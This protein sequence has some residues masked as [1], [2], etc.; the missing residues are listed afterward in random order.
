[1]ASSDTVSSLTPAAR[2]GECVV[3]VGAGLAGLFTA[4]K[5]SPH[6]VVLISPTPLG[7]G[8]ASG[9]AQGGI[10]A[11]MSEGDTPEAH[12]LDT[13]R[14]GCGIVD[15][16]MA[17]LLAAE[18]AER[19]DDLLRLGVPFDR[20]LEGKL[21]L[22]REAAHG[23]RRI[24]RV[25]GD[26]AGKAIMSAVT[27]AVRQTPSI[28][29][30]T[31]AGVH[32]LTLS[33]G[34]VTGVRVW[35]AGSLGRGEPEKVRAR[36]VVLAS[37]GIGQLYRVTTNPPG[38]CGEG[39]AIAARAGATIADAEFVQF[40]PT[41]LDIGRDPAPLAT[42]ALRGEGALLINSQGKRY[43]VEAHE[44]AELAPR[45]VV[46]RATFGEIQAGRGAFIDCRKAIG[47]RFAE[48]FPALFEICADAGI[49]PVHQ[50]IP[51]APAAHYHMG[52]VLT[53]SDGRTTVDGLW[54][55]GEVACTG[56][57]GANRLA[58][59]SLLET[60]V[61]G[62][63]IANDISGYLPG[64]TARREHAR[65]PAPDTAT[66]T[67]AAKIKDATAALRQTMTSNAGVVRDAQGL[68]DA[69]TLVSQLS[70]SG[71][72]LAM[73]NWALTARFIA[74]AA[75]RREESRG[76]H[77]RTDFPEERRAWKRHSFLTLDD[78]RKL[79]ETAFRTEHDGGRVVHAAFGS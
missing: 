34:Q 19:I 48:A 57:H 51:I 4:L 24:A 8:T 74:V 9:W 21:Q 45:D 50:P 2:R 35:P 43:M 56:A 70:E 54:A 78:V 27:A 61:F 30:L 67:D 76:A 41:A 63:R 25:K 73:R 71:W 26:L 11:A 49:D 52:G 58:S 28:E 38:A 77:F 12:A 1:M 53:D 37:G 31:G 47:S 79:T 40:H 10:A 68:G 36:A 29:V 3:V 39:V 16:G 42:E 75:Q 14:A 65:P 17:R 22:S 23:A 66:V 62:A 5:L 18:A 72:P 60:V 33:H 15:E 64:M 6:P 7:E 59:N 44:D 55:C 32:E 20:D 13:I 69:L 46:A